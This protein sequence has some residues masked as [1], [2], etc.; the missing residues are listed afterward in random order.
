MILLVCVSVTA[1]LCICVYLCVS[2]CVLVGLI[3]ENGL[4]SLGVRVIVDNNVINW[5]A[6]LP[7]AVGTRSDDYKHGENCPPQFFF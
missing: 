3:V 2:V 7:T 5:H 4:R 1:C 6:V